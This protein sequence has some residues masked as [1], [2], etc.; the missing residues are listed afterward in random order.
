MEMFVRLSLH[1]FLRNEMESYAHL[2][3]IGPE[4]GSNKQKYSVAIE[5]FIVSKQ[6]HVYRLTNSMELTPSWEAA[7]CAATQELSSI[8]WNPKVHYRTHRSPPMVPILSQIDLVHTIPFCLSKIHFN[9]VHPPT[10]LSS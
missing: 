3:I 9:I 6:R 5:V 8:L 10:S 4:N 2:L 7:N 1:N